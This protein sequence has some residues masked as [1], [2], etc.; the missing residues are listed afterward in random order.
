MSCMHVDVKVVRGALL[1]GMHL[2]GS[3]QVMSREFSAHE[4]IGGTHNKHI[5]K[6][7]HYIFQQE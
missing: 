7:L 3:V 5:L 4:G 2:W 6:A 1:F